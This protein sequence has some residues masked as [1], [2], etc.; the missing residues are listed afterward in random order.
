LLMLGSM[1]VAPTGRPL[2][3]DVAAQ[4]LAATL[5]GAA[6]VP[7]PG[8]PDGTGRAVITLNVGQAQ[9]C[10]DIQVAGIAPANAAHIHVG[11]AGVDGD[12]VVPLAAPTGG[13]ASGCGAAE[14]AVIEGIVGNPP[15]YYVN[16]HNAEHP[17]G[18]IRGQL[19]EPGA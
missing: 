17:A 5:T 4:S 8:D 16:V 18:A 7:G 2:D 11:A 6:E 14:R 9:V 15:G 1:G 3:S 10:W 19:G 13:T 12:I